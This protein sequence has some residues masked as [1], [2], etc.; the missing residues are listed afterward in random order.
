M[1]KF[2]CIV[3]AL[4]SIFVT[5]CSAV[6]NDGTSKDGNE[7]SDESG[8]LFTYP[9]GNKDVTS[10]VSEEET[11]A[12]I[13]ESS[14]T[15]S[16]AA[17]SGD[18]AS[19]AEPSSEEPSSEEP[20]SAEPSTGEPSTEEPSNEPVTSEPSAE[21]SN[22]AVSEAGESSEVSVPPVIEI[23]VEESN[24]GDVWVNDLRYQQDRDYHGFP[25]EELDH[26][27]D[28]ALF[29]GDSVCQGLKLYI[30]N[31]EKIFQ[32]MTFSVAAAYGFH[33]SLSPVSSKSLHPLYQGQKRT[34]W[35]MVALTNPNKVFI[36]FGLNDFGCTTPESNKNC[37]DRIIANI[38]AV[39]P[40][41][42]II[43][44]SA[45]YFTKAGESYR[46]SLNDYRTNARHR[47]YN[48][49]MLEYCNAIG[50]DYIDVSNGIADDY[51]YLPKEASL[52]NYCH[53]KIDQYT[54]WRDILYSYA[55][56]KIL[57]TY[58]NPPRMK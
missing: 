36:G 15:A 29:V 6:K 24:Y 58:Q 12:Y 39:K 20:S 54:L 25:P 14:Q 30:D 48:Q 17:S 22:E 31:H 4:L 3:L 46:P 26:Y 44:L 42:E 53:M 45:G 35:E 16:E 52:D 2:L 40:D 18:E 21:F 47:D 10:Y 19:P 32:G 49:Y 50:L 23:L 11:S 9:A 57:G 43:I 8:I 51:G 37:L 28:D 38:R 1:R 56:N 27:F 34:I 41:V 33:N 13:G 5:A 7:N 55:A